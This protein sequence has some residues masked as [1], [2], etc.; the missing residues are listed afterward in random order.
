MTDGAANPANPASTSSSGNAPAPPFAVADA[1]IRAAANADLAIP[2]LAAPDMVIPGVPALLLDRARA[3]LAAHRGELANT[4]IIGIA[5][6]AVHSSKPR[7]Y[8]VD[9]ARGTVRSFRVTH[10]SGSDRDHDGYLDLFSNVD[11]SNATSSG[12]FRTGEVY[13]GA[14]GRA[15]RL[16][17]LDASNSAARSRAIVMHTAWYAE[18]D[19]V[20]A[21]HKLGRSQGCFTFSAEDLPAVMASLPP[22]SLIYADRA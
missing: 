3:S 13:D 12:A 11:G 21:Q 5:D 17:G 1:P 16:D 4:Q 20:A 14:Y 19:V 22:G 2:D 15:E 8:I 9:L 6:F 18:P 10:G 7:F